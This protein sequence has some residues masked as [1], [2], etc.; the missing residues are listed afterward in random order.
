MPYYAH[1]KATQNHM[2]LRMFAVFL[3]LARA[4]S[5]VVK[6]VFFCLVSAQGDITFRRR[7]ATQINS[8]LGFVLNKNGAGHFK[9]LT[10]KEVD[11]LHEV[12]TWGLSDL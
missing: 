7:S 3:W 4:P 8:T 5:Y 11:A 6:Y 9:G 10:E 12:L 2:L 1:N